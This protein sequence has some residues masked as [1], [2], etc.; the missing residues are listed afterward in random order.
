MFFRSTEDLK[1]CFTV[2]ASF[3]F[4]EF[5]LYLEDVDSSILKKYLGSDF[6][7]EVQEAFDDANQVAD[8]VA[9][10]YKAIV[11]LIR[12]CSPHFALAK[13]LPYGQVSIS[14]TG[15]HINVSETKKTA[16]AWQI[17][18]IEDAANENG[19][20]LLDDL[21]LY[22]E[23]NLSTYGT[24]KDSDEYKENTSLFVSTASEFSK[25]CSPFKRS[26]LNF[27]RIR[28][29]IRKVEDFDIKSTILP[30]Y[31]TDLKTT[32]AAGTTLGTNA[33]NALE[34][35]KPAVVNLAM[36]K[37]IRELSANMS[38]EGVVTF[39]N[40]ASTQSVENIQSAE[41]TRLSVIAGSCEN[42]GKTYLKNLRAYLEAN[43]AD[44]P[45]FADDALYV[46]PAS[47]VQQ[48]TGDKPF[49]TGISV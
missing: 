36:A 45:L 35:I 8:D 3:K 10:P 12:K 19:F 17:K 14:T 4:E 42:D 32:I 47:E 21:L 41:I 48:N 26:I 40:T 30:D 2:I 13:W 31:F 11:N 33:K 29:I 15:V 9:D 49:F 39:N 7:D 44:Y 1:T 25:Y 43:K 27:M 20:T 23:K 24:Y 18:K 38:S 5:K 28:S 6:F 34:L 37:A 16:F 22:L 46:E